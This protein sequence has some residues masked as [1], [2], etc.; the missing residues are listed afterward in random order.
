MKV[1]MK[2]G[3]F[4]K[5]TNYNILLFWAHYHPNYICHPEYKEGSLG[6]KKN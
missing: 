2:E 6:S 5:K 1:I 4:V 3:Q